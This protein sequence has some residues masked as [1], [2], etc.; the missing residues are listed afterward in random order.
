LILSF[1]A[2]PSVVTPQQR[3]NAEQIFLK[4]R[5]SKSPY[6]FCRQVL[7]KNDKQIFALLFPG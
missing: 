4:L 7:G 6:A 1:Q 5:K 3:H 2:S